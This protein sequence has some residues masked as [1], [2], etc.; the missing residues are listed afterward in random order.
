MKWLDRI[1]CILVAVIFVGVWFFT[2]WYLDD[3]EPTFYR[4]RAYSQTG[5]KLG[6]WTSR[7]MLSTKSN[8]GWGLRD[9]ETG[10]MI[11]FS[12]TVDLVV[13]EIKEPE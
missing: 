6:E 4:V 2:I 1:G 5:E 3:F 10:K 11:Y 12:R 8:D 7:G 9:H 13:E